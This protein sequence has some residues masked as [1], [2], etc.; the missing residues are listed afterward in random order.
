M[1]DDLIVLAEIRIPLDRI[2]NAVTP[3]IHQ[4][5]IK[6]AA[7]R[8]KMRPTDAALKNSLERFVSALDHLERVK[9]TVGEPAAH[10]A[11]MSAIKGVRKAYI[12]DKKD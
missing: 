6:K 2:V 5:L 11:L 9:H 1:T 10:E 3:E 12:L 8:L 7:P 4:A